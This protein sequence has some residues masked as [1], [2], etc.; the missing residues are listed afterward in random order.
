M[1]KS[2]VTCIMC[3]KT[4]GKYERAYVVDD[5]GV[6]CKGCDKKHPDFADGSA[7]KKITP[8]KRMNV[9]MRIGLIT[10][11]VCI[12]GILMMFIPSL[13]EH[14][15][16]PDEPHWPYIVA[17]LG[18]ILPS[19]YGIALFKQKRKQLWIIFLIWTAGWL[20][21]FGCH[22]RYGWMEYH[23]G[24]HF[25]LDVI[26]WFPTSAFLKHVIDIFN[27]YAYQTD[28]MAI[29]GLVVFALLGIG[30]WG[31]SKRPRERM[32]RKKWKKISKRNK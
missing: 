12:T 19:L 2:E 10:A 30:A 26:V 32:S 22:I 3:G 11:V 29:N 14:L 21:S 15:S 23:P 28:E 16:S 25:C 1:G 31:L 13:L 20:I 4:I 7:L 24:W 6:I 18:L 8:K 17:P 5:D 9:Q 27:V